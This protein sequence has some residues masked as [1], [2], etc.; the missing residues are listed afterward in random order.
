MSSPHGLVGGCFTEKLLGS[1]SVKERPDGQPAYL[2]L[3]VWRDLMLE[4]QEVM[5]RGLSAEERSGKAMAGESAI[6]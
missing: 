5:D 3:C 1:S 2:L 4:M 6:G